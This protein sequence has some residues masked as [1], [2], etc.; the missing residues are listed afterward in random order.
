MVVELQRDMGLTVLSYTSALSQKWL[1]RHI[2]MMR[3]KN[4][5]VEGADQIP[6][7]NWRKGER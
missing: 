6:N 1:Y 5:P 2:D 7:F 3:L 4:K